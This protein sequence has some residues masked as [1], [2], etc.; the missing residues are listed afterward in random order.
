MQI[1][2]E[3]TYDGIPRSQWVDDYIHEQVRR[4]DHMCEGLMSCRVVVAREQHHNH[5]GNPFRA[6]VKVTI[7]PKKDLIGDKIGQVEDPQVQLRPIIRKA[8]EAVEKQLRKQ[9]ALRRGETKYHEESRAL[10]VRLFPEQGYGFIKSPTDGQEYFFH[11]NAVLH[12]DFDRL[13][14][15]TE[16]RFEPEMGEDG[17][18]ASTVQIVGKPGARAEEKASEPSAGWENT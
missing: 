8:F 17:P 10:V 15:G 2:L 12:G 9:T 1:P 3:I 18:Q 6:R 4:L 7:P 14:P 16:V 13:E 11:R 5:T